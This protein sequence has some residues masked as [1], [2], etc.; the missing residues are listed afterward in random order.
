MVRVGIGIVKTRVGRILGIPV[1]SG[2]DVK[3]ASLPAR[4]HRI[5]SLTS[6]KKPIEVTISPRSDFNCYCLVA[7]C[8]RA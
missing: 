4:I 2:T 1:A 6:F 3:C 5:V 8:D 7:T